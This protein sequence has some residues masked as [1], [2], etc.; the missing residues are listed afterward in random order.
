MCTRCGTHCRQTQER[1]MSA[2]SVE[3]T[4]Q[5]A[6]ITTLEEVMGKVKAA[7][8]LVAFLTQYPFVTKNA[9]CRDME[10]IKDIASGSRELMDTLN[11]LFDKMAIDLLKRTKRS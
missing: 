7:N 9:T 1:G 2:S 10:L 4:Q 8:R 11:S 6:S 3:K 5:I